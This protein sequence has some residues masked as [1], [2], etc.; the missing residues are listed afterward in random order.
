MLGPELGKKETEK[1]R[2][3]T[4]RKDLA[5]NDTFVQKQQ[6]YSLSCPSLSFCLWPPALALCSL[7]SVGL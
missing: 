6:S 7:H 3:A 2:K 1:K 4:G 5:E